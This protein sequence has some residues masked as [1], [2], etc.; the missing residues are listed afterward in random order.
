MSDEF[1]TP[2]R[3]PSADTPK[4][5]APTL[6]EPSAEGDHKALARNSWV[7]FTG[8][9]VSRALG[10]VR[11]WLLAAAI[12][13]FGIADAFN[14]A[15]L[16]P[17]TIY[18]LLAGGVLNAILVPSIVRSLRRNQNGSQEGT[19]A[20]NALLTLAS[21]I[22]LGITLIA[23]A[24]AWPLTMLFSAKIS[25]EL[26]DLTVVFAIWFL[27]QIFFYGLYALWGQVLNSL[28]SFGPYMWAPVVNNLVSI[29]GLLAF[30][31]LY[32]FAPDQNTDPTPWHG[33]RLILLTATTTGGIVLQALV[34][35][36]PLYH[37]GFQLRF[38][39]K[40]RG[41]GLRHTGKVAGWAFAALSMG[42]IS[43]WAVIYVA[44]AANGWG[45]AHDTFVISTAIHT[46]AH[47]LYML[48]QALV[49]TSITTALFTAMSRQA[50]A[51]DYD[52]LTLSFVKSAR[53]VGF[54]TT[55]LTA[56]LIVGALPLTNLTVSTLPPDQAAAMAQ[57]LI[58][59]AVSIPFQGLA[60]ANLRVFYALQETRTVFL[61][62]LP[63]LA[64]TVLFSFGS[65]YL[66][67][68]EWW[69]C[70]AVAG[71]SVGTAATG[72]V[73]IIALAKRGIKPEAIFKISSGY[74]RFIVAAAA[75][76]LV[77]FLVLLP[78]G[79]SPDAFLTDPEAW[80]T[81][82]HF[83]GGL[84]RSAVIGVVVGGVY[85]AVCHALKVQEVSDIFATLK[86]KLGRVKR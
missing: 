15:N 27:P 48:P 60:V 64:L 71:D 70:G 41:I 62:Q 20:V 9:F 32:G 78:A 29:A 85:L 28:S 35:L 5:P 72:L 82:G 33:T 76:A 37:V 53:L 2:G 59:M 68:A 24:C 58:I 16:L 81:R 40:I 44:S 67:P 73:G 6:R 66:L 79:L 7:M 74:A 63:L 14:T 38:S 19:D 17:N 65:L 69:V 18:N 13:A 26:F 57:L 3:A 83:F 12:G 22:L 42:T 31:Q 80:S 61:L 39:L 10:F 1:P 50:D 21:M 4:K 54:F 47:Q 84:W 45:Q 36:I 25:P 8:T 52:G 46:Y 34:L 49:T 43:F 56:M 55:V 75:A 86:Q 77:G 23:V 51:G 11:I 30:L